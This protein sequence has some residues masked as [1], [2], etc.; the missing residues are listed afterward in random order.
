MPLTGDQLVWCK[1]PPPGANKRGTRR[2]WAAI[3]YQLREHPGEWAL[4]ADIDGNLTLAHRIQHGHAWWAPAGAFE[5]ATR[6]IDGR[7]HLW[8]RYIGDPYS[9]R[10]PNHPSG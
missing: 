6:M 1:P 5:T 8:A 3:A 4:V 2:A 10:Q 7:L 9:R